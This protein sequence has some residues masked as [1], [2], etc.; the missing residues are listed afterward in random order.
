LSGAPQPLDEHRCRSNGRVV[1]LSGDGLRYLLWPVA[2]EPGARLSCKTWRPNR[3]QVAFAQS[4]RYDSPLFY[5][6]R[7]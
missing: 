4:R 7:I 5:W 2:E 1:W 6:L 3:L